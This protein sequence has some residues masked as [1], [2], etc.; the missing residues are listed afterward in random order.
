VSTTPDW[1]QSRRKRAEVAAI[2]GLGYPLLRTLE[3]TWRWKVS[4]AEHDLAIT[5]AGHQPILALWHGRIL[6]SVVFFKNRGIVPMA[7]ENFDGEWITRLL[8]RF[9]YGAARGSTTRGGAMALR[10]L[11]REIKAK[12][13]AIT[14]DGP[15]GPAEVAQPGAVWLA[16]A[17]GNPLLPIHSEAASSWTLK[18]WDR[19]QIPKPFTTVAMAIGEPIYVPRDADDKALESLRLRL[20]DSLKAC[21]ARCA[22]LLCP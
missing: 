8:Y 3:S 13:V 7:S 17:S 1:R 12:G 19:T 14:L 20:E 15:R 11:V 6:T 16:K 5:A 2:S 9:G 22:E 21:K 18:S 10:Q 4:G